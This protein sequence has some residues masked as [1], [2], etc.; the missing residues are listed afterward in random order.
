MVQR[1]PF[2]ARSWNG[3][4]QL[5]RRRRLPQINRGR[6]ACCRR[7]V[8]HIDTTDVRPWHVPNLRIL[9]ESELTR[10]ESSEKDV[11]SSQ[12]NANTHTLTLPSIHLHPALVVTLVARYRLSANSQASWFSP[13]PCTHT[14]MIECAGGLFSSLGC[15]VV[16]RGPPR[17][18]KP[19]TKRSARARDGRTGLTAPAPLHTHSFYTPF[20][21]QHS[22]RAL[23]SRSAVHH[24]RR[25]D[26][27]GARRRFRACISRR[28]TR[29]GGPVEH[30]LQIRTRHT[31]SAA[32]YLFDIRPLHV[33]FQHLDILHDQRPANPYTDGPTGSFLPFLPIQSVVRSCDIGSDKH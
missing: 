10:V 1:R 15:E 18:K 13:I 17:D 16:K 28:R 23:L 7:I 14:S 32:T 24:A 33:C 29:C 12:Y 27:D 9:P 11:P 6:D 31:S 4:P 3:I 2:S 8:L 19:Y 21:G 5:F 30:L 20:P 25:T 22:P 26:L